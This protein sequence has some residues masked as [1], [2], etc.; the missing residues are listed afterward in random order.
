MHED[1]IFDTAGSI[2]CQLDL[3]VGRKG[4]NRL[5]QPNCANAGQI[6][7][8]ISTSFKLLCDID[9]QPQISCNQLFLDC[10]IGQPDDHRLFFLPRQW[11]RQRPAPGH[12][13]EYIFRL[14]MLPA[15]LPVICAAVRLAPC[16]GSQQACKQVPDLPHDQMLH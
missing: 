10:G 14:V 1:F 2:G 6:L 4:I 9:D 13:I 15:Q 12:I 8:R 5:D 11:R 7:Q 16:A 3:F